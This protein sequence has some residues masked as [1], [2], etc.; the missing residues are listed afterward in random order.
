V[1]IDALRGQQEQNREQRDR[2]EINPEITSPEGAFPRLGD[3]FFRQKFRQGD[4]SKYGS[5]I[6]VKI[7]AISDDENTP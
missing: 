2:R 1:S 5:G 3:T 7:T 6:F 4:N